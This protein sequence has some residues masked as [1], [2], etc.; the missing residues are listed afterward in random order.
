M[1]FVGEVSNI[2]DLANLLHRKIGGLPMTY[3]SMP[4]GASFK[5]NFVWNPILEKIER[6]LSGWKKLCLS[7][8]GRLTLLKSTFFSILI[9]SCCSL[10]LL[11]WRIGLRSCR[12]FFF[13]FFGWYGV[14]CV[15]NYNWWI[16]LG[17]VE[18]NFVWWPDPNNVAWFLMG[19]LLRLRKRNLVIRVFGVV[20]FL[21]WE[22]NL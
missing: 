11:V 5:E 19:D 9:I 6:R 12:N 7:K 8:G 10:A 15:P 4:L 3:L 22:E 21:V 20:V 16:V 2:S 14:R 17:F 1:V 18:P 13:F